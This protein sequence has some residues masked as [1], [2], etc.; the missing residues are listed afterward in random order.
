MSGRRSWDNEAYAKKAKE[1]AEMGDDYDTQ[2]SKSTQTKAT[3]KEEFTK[4]DDGALGPMGSER[5]FLKA[6]EERVDLESKVGKTQVINQS[7]LERG[8]GAGYFCETCNCL[9]KD[10]ISYLDHINGKKHLRALG[11]S[12]RVER[13]GVDKVKDKLESLKRKISEAK[14]KPKVSAI[15]DYDTRMAVQRTEEEALKKKRKEEKRARKQ[16][17]EINEME[18]V[19]PEIA[20]MMGFS[21]F[22]SS[23]K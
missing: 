18:G 9:L 8:A 14:D 16:E 4:A 20:E 21:G 1:R 15:E 22:G 17:R 7:E 19:D 6:R 12:M 10:S 13:A 3:R 5:A 2:D 11:F 23:K